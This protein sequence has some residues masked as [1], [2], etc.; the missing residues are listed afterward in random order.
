[1]NRTRSKADWLVDAG[2]HW[3]DTPRQVAES[4]DVAFTM[5]TDTPALRV[6]TEG[7]DGILAGLSADKIYVD[8]SSISPAA[9]RALAADVEAKGARMLDAPVS[10][11]VITLEE[12]RLSIMVGGDEDTFRTLEPILKDIGPTVTHVG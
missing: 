7:P 9:S 2:M 4:A 12:G 5:V 10:G 11:S 8:M 6:V 3:A 1:T